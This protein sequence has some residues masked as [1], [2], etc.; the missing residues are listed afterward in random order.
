MKS[1]FKCAETKER[2]FCHLPQEMKKSCK[3][4][5]PVEGGG[6]TVFVVG[7]RAG[8]KTDKIDNYRPGCPICFFEGN[9]PKSCM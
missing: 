9:G 4:D 1:N 5:S 7:H 2:C 8:F 6:P 3:T